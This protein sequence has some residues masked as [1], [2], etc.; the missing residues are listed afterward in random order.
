MAYE[1]R[2]GPGNRLGIY[3]DKIEAIRADRGL[4]EKGFRLDGTDPAKNDKEA[5]LRDLYERADAHLPPG[6]GGNPPA[7]AGDETDE[8][9]AP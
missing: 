2:S 5:M 4:D 1:T 3:A 6:L 7:N 8:D 9:D